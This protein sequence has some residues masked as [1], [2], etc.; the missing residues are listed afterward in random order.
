MLKR[1]MYGS[2]GVLAL[3]VAFHLGSATAKAGGGTVVSVGGLGEWVWAVTQNGDVYRLRYDG[4]GL[5]AYHSN[6]FGAVAME[7]STWGQIK[8]RAAQ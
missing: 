8:H 3:A 4:T 1:F 6:L 2:V 5:W 7:P